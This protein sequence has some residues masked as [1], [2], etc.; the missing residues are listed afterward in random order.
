MAVLNATYKIEQSQGDGTRTIGTIWLVNLGTKENPRVAIVTAHHVFLGMK[1][2]NAK[3]HWRFQD[4]NGIWKREPTEV[5]IRNDNGNPLWLHHPEKDIAVMWVNAPKAV[6]DNALFF[7][8]LADE[9][10]IAAL[11]ISMGDEMLA[12]G[13]PRGLSANDL[14][15][16]ILRSGR[17]AS[18]PIVPLRQFPTF[19]MDFSVF[20]GNSGGPV[21]MSNKIINRTIDGSYESKHF[22]AGLLS[23]QVNKDAERL[24]IGIVIH[25]NFIRDILRELAGD[26]DELIS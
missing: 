22:V 26:E 12:L 3:V 21:Y 5:K 15:F 1:Q 14:G 23:Q 6:I 4:E 16:P 24:E 13:Y 18:Y 9:R 11:E 25:A 10:T 17:V 20:S 19:L 8:N 2:E 7:D